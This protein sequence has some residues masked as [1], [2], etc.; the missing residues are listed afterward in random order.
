MKKIIKIS[1]LVSY[2]LVGQVIN[3][4]GAVY[5]G[6]YYNIDKLTRTASVTRGPYD[7]SG[8][9]YIARFIKVD[10]VTYRVTRIEN[11]VFYNCKKIES[12]KIPDTIIDIGDN[13]FYECSNIKEITIPYSVVSIGS[14]A[15]GVC[16]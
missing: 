7:Y 12:V 1:I 8:T 9:I 14:Y 3:A 11:G 2:L 6:V 10:G 16:I 15:F 13:A 5:Q 4:A